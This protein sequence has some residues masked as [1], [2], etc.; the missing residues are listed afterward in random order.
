MLW[1][2]LVIEMK[3]HLRLDLKKTGLC[4]IYLNIEST[5]TDQIK[6]HFQNQLHKHAHY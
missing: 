1:T 5:N 2:F 3:F 6:K 4:N